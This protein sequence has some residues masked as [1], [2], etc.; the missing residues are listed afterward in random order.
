MS[1]RDLA[2]DARATL[3]PGFVGCSA[4]G[5]LLEALRDGLLAV[6]VY[7]GNVRDRAQLARLG[8]EL[9]AAAP[10]ALVA[11]DEEGGEVT[12]LHYLEGAPYPGAAV[13]GRIDDP[14]YTEEIG[15]RVGRDILAC[16]FDLALA[17]DADVNSDPR[18]PVIGTRSFGADP[19]LA[20]RHVAAWV[21]G[22]QGTGAIACPK[23]FPGHGATTQDSHLAL[24]VVDASPELLARRDLP[25]FR[26]AVRAGAHAVMTS[27]ILLPQVDATGPA[28]FSRPLL[29]GMLREQ[30]GFD[31]AIVSDAL[32]MRGACDRIG[33][34]EAAVRA[35]A[36][37]CDLLC[38]GTDTAPELL[39]DIEEHVIAA[40]HAGRIAA[41]RVHE[42][43]D[44]VR[45]LASRS[46]LHGSRRDAAAAAAAAAAADTTADTT[47]DTAAAAPT[48]GGA[49]ATP[50]T[51]PA[52]LPSAAEVARVLASFDGVD[53]ARAWLR[54][55][56]HA[57]VVR[58]ET[59]SNL[60]VGAA[61]WGPFAAAARPLAHQRAAAAAFARRPQHTV[62][63][64]S[65]VPWPVPPGRDALVI[66]RDLHRHEFARDGIDALRGSGRETLTVDMGW[67]GAGPE[68]SRYADLASYGSSALAGAALLALIEEGRG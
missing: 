39:R 64:Q 6:C 65:A 56:P 14:A 36:A 18:N 41:D 11:I 66:G 17:P 52:A 51:A 34:P 54:A 44:R 1:A 27:H 58:V 3:M 33:I 62:N 31:G 32:D 48:T 20:A 55:H 15:A 43:A 46:G 50:R 7:G 63:E 38:L 19:E 35:L 67:P 30:L 37:G 45:A 13:L 59:G 24:P 16:G 49:G 25:P 57:C 68:T 61:P 2:R 60:A 5:W 53:A 42:A 9:R 12:R 21:R 10:H 47:A 40:V 28:T 26:A 4:P 8:S 22:L 29:Q 23:H